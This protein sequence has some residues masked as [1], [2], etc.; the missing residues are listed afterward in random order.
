MKNPR[1]QLMLHAPN[2]AESNISIKY[3]GVTII[4]T[5]KV[6]NKNYL[7]IDLVIS[8]SAKPGTASIRLSNGKTIPFELK[9]RR[10][11]NGTEYAQV[12]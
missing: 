6:E 4:K 10:K 1:L 8:K 9:P 3:P 7:L 2:V 11:G 12:C 5:N